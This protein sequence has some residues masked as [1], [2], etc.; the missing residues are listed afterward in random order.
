[1][2]YKRQS[3]Y[4]RN[5]CLWLIDKVGVREDSSVFKREVHE[6]EATVNHVQLSCRAHISVYMVCTLVK[7]VL[8]SCVDGMGLGMRVLLCD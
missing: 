1:M 2:L 3:P 5:K 4:I 6:P 7:S 8:G